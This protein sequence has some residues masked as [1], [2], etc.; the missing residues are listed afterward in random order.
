MV[1]IPIAAIAVL[2][3]DVTGDSQAGKADAQVSTGLEAAISVYED[4][5][6]AADKAAQKVLADRTVASALAGGSAQEIE[7]ATAVA[8]VDIGLKYLTLTTPD[9]DEL[10][11]IPSDAPVAAVTVTDAGGSELSLVASTISAD[12]YLGRVEELTGLS[13]AV[14]GSSG[15]AVAA[16]GVDTE[17]L[18]EAGATADAE[19]DGSEARA[20]TASLGDEGAAVTVFAP[21]EGAG[22]FDSRPRVALL[23]AVF[24][25]IALTGVAVIARTLQS[26][27]A[28][29]LGAARR[30]GSGDFSQRVPVVG[31]DEMAGL[32]SEFNKMT[33]Q[34]EA[35][36][37]Q[38]RRQRK[39][40]DRSVRRMGE[41]FAAGLDREALLAIVAETALGACDAEYARVTFTDGE[42]IEVPEGFKGP[43]RDAAVAGQKRVDREGA[44]VDARRGE[45]FA[46]AAPL[47]TISDNV[48]VGSLSIG[49]AGREFADEDRDVFLYLL[50]QTSVSIDN[51]STHEKVSEQA[52]TD[53]LTGLPN[54]RAFRETIDREASRAE[55][56][57]H[58]LSLI[59]L[60]VDDFKS[61]NDTYGH[62]QGDEVLRLIGKLLL[63]EPRAIDE[64]ARYGGEEFVVALPETGT[65]GAVELAERIRERLEE[66]EIPLLDGSGVLKVTASFGTATVPL[67]AETVRQLFAAADDALYEAKRSGK[68]RVVTAPERVTVGG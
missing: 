55:R 26:Q 63:E 65:D 37:S 56:F 48:Q 1:A 20:A 57:E 35:Q 40:L 66:E 13:A 59:I 23:V 18:P 28:T 31:R 10:E 4:E 45:G 54:N 50:G 15:S 11:P 67:S 27:I 21:V 22:F 34:L 32:A 60:D 52:V 25:A 43:A 64:P 12:E 58:E 24:L 16:E 8:G 61:V 42:L 36:I 17:S 9:G 38:L 68:N 7:R 39:E 30:I 47:K 53:E 62:L 14:I 44:K 19:I 33:D 51:I 6:A 41:A 29:M 5:V 2:A 46:L 3:S 49:R